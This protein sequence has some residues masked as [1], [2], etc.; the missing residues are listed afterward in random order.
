[1]DKEAVNKIMRKYVVE[2]P[3][4]ART[5]KEYQLEERLLTWDGTKTI[6]ENRILCGYASYGAAFH[7]ATMLN[8]PHATRNTEEATPEVVEDQQPT[9]RQVKG[10]LIQILMKKDLLRVAMNAIADPGILELKIPKAKR[11]YRRK[12]NGRKSRVIHTDQ[13]YK[14]HWDSKL[15]L[16]GLKRKFKVHTSTIL[17]KSEALNLPYK[18]G[19]I[20]AQRVARVMGQAS[21]MAGLKKTDSQLEMALSTK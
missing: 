17:R 14:A 4:I 19:R 6:E 18:M 13:Y 2:H 11:A 8:L 3:S 9:W 20:K 7:L 5:K 10:F 16:K 15:T 21:S 12:K 1:M